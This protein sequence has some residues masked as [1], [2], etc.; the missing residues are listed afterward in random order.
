MG[1]NINEKKEEIK[2]N[3]FNIHPVVFFWGLSIILAGII[4]TLAAGDTAEHIFSTAYNF[5]TS[6][7]D[8][9]YIGA[10]NLAVIFCLY[11]LFSRFGK[12]RL[13]GEDA[14]PEFTTPGWLSMLFSAGM[15]I[16]ILF[17]GVAEPL[18]HYSSMY[19]TNPLA[20][21]A[22]ANTADKSL[23]LTFFHWGLHPWA[24]FSLVGLGIA[25]F[26]FSRK[27]TFSIRNIF[28][29]L[30]KDR[31]YGWQGNLIDIIAVVSTLYGV[32][33]SLGLGVQQINAGIANVFEIPDNTGFQVFLIAL[34]TSFATWSV[35]RGL[36]KGIKFLSKINICVAGILMVLIFFTG[37]SAYILQ[38]FFTGFADYIKEIIP[39]SFNMTYKSA[40]SHKLT[41]FYWGWGIAWSPF[42][43][44][45]IA[46]ISYGRTIKEFLSGVL[47]VP[48]FVTF[49][50]LSVFG[51]SALFYEII[52]NT[53]LAEAVTQSVPVSLFVFLENFPF[54]QFASLLAVIVVMTFFITSSDSASLVIDIIS[55][56]G[57]PE[58]PKLQRVFWAVLEGL[59]AAVL[60]LGGGLLA[61]KT[62]A[63]VTGF[64]FA[65]V[66]IIMVFSVYKGLGDYLAEKA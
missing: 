14:V 61:L 37:P 46:R 39:L 2:N 28:Y 6:Y 10:V 12:I 20:T 7:L 27:Q 1:Y 17:Y 56:G 64:P 45:F 19:V 31:I 42:V 53:G 8:F 25:F 11:L 41:I 40:E 44:M 22:Q 48:V 35:I 43:G 9:V 33:T 62:A 5:I 36:D 52:K 30:L 24:I 51:K 18:V 55:A 38:G 16:G 34:I 21:P 29:P 15:G 26:G 50:W 32:A 60:L 57:D 4:F 3:L 63:V 65:I 49:I 66:L 58:P 59:A 54:S 47:L 13:G 23:L